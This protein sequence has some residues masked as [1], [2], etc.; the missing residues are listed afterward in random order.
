MVS[1]VAA[2][3]VSAVSV[4]SVAYALFFAP[5]IGD[6]GGYS[7]GTGNPLDVNPAKANNAKLGDPIRELFGRS[8]IY[9]D[10]AVQP[11]SRF[12]PDD[13]TVMTVEMFVVLGRGRFSFGKREPQPTLY[14]IRGLL[15]Q[16]SK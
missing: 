14:L 15:V 13:P 5:G 11:V 12:S 2:S 7:S 4:A 10:Y 6:L 1:P 9:P 8:R 16:L 3:V